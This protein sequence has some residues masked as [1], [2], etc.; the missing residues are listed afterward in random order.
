M[1][2]KV[3]YEQTKQINPFVLR[4]KESGTDDLFQQGKDVIL[5]E[6]LEDYI[7]YNMET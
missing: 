5:F 3:K 7:H 4:A 1:K 6:F 2:D